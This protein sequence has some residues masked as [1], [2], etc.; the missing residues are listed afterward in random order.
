MSHRTI[1]A[2]AAFY[3]AVVIAVADETSNEAKDLQGTWQA[4]DLEA[5]GQ[6]SPADQV[7][8]LKIVI[9]GDEIYAVK[10]KGEDPRSKFKLDPKKQPKAIDL[11]PETAPPRGRWPGF[12]HCGMGNSGLH[13]PFWERHHSTAQGIQDQGRRWS[14]FRHSRDV[15]KAKVDDALDRPSDVHA[16]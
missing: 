5:N 6:K 9:Q 13:Q 2:L 1:C 15:C 12:T 8:E 10:P 7:S 11:F 4:V 3:F 14:R 16:S